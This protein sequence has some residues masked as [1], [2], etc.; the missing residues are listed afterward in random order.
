MNTIKS[1]TDF[2]IL[3]MLMYALNNSATLLSMYT[4]L[5]KS[6]NCMKGDE[7]FTDMVF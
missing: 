2:Y 6:L 7:T 3:K 1:L 4:L 5:Y